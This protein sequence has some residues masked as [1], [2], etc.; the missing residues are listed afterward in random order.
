MTRRTIRAALRHL[1]ADCDYETWFRVSA[2]IFN[3]L[4]GEGLDLF[5]EWSA[6][7]ST[8]PG[9][10]RVEQHWR[11]LRPRPKGSRLTVGSLRSMLKK[12]G[13]SW[14]QVLTEAGAVND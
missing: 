7:G 5:D 10:A 3:T 8:Y 1:D 11:Y 14:S 9:R 6:T 2:I 4:G 13:V 12:A